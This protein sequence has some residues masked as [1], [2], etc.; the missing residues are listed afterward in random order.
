MKDNT[1]K[2]SNDEKTQAVTVI[3]AIVKS[4]EYFTNDK[5]D[6][7]GF[8]FPG[9][10]MKEKDGISIMANGP[11]NP[12]MLKELNENIA[13]NIGL[14]IKLKKIY[15]DSLSCV[16]GER[17]Y[18]NGKLKEISN[19][20]YIGGGTGIADGILHNKKL[21]D[22][23]VEK[24]LKKSWEIIM[25]N[26]DT[27]EECISLAGLCKKWEKRKPVSIELLNNLFEKAS[28]KHELATDIIETAG[29]AFQLLI[30]ERINF[31]KANKRFPEKIVIGQRLGQILKKE[32]HPL[33]I[34]FDNYNSHDIP[35]ELS[36]SD[37]TAALGVAQY[38]INE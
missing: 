30:N 34:I 36:S 25:P 37:N 33:K 38:A 15:D 28:E 12:Y 21:I 24:D 7:V 23:S 13:K 31:F 11:R 20:I 2:I 32:N 18:P 17:F 16:N 1:Y 4:I 14:N 35:I 3:K 5:I 6:H 26:G 27:I 29:Q 19:A 8:C 9:I 22:I 10:K